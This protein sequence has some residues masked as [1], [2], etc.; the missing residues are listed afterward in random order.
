M[1]Y[2]IETKRLGLRELEQED[3]GAL[4]LFLQDIEVMYAWEY[5]FSDEQ[6]REFISNQQ[7][8]YEVDGFGYYAAVEKE[9]DKVIGCMGPLMEQVDRCV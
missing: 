3:F 8:R 5:A 9:S 1:Q 7:K 6:V 4:C 2:I